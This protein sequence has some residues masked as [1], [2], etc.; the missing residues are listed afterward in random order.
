MGKDK[1]NRL[2]DSLDDKLTFGVF[3]HY[4]F[5][6]ISRYDNFSFPS[7]IFNGEYVFGFFFFLMKITLNVRFLLFLAVVLDI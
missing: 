1:D 5:S 6:T 7:I 4:F 2:R 3:P